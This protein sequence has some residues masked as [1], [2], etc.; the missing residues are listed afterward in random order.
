MPLEVRTKDGSLG[1]CTGG[2]E[3]EVQ[4]V[5]NPWYRFRERAFP[6]SSAEGYCRMV[7]HLIGAA[8]E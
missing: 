8:T 7:L 5:A 4:L 1:A 3:Y 6:L 2:V